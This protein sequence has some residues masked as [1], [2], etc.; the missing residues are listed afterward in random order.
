MEVKDRDY[1]KLFRQSRQYKTRLYKFRAENIELKSKLKK[2]RMALEL[3]CREIEILEELRYKEKLPEN[4]QEALVKEFL[5]QAEH[6]AEILKV[7]E[8][9]SEL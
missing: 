8:S 4:S 5:D 9:R 3:A 6:D 1:A 7:G 2:T